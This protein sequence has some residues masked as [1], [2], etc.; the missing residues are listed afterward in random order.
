M[1]GPRHP[2]KHSGR[3]EMR[4]LMES[5]QKTVTTLPKFGVNRQERRHGTKGWRREHIW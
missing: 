1:E 5:L 3:R 4:A 2:H